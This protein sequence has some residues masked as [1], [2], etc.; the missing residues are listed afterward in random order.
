[1]N[2]G[3]L[4]LGMKRVHPAFQQRHEFNVLAIEIAID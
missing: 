4:I 1:M 2:S 3:L